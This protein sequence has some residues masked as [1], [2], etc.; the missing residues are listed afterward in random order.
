MTVGDIGGRTVEPMQD[1]C[2]VQL[3]QNKAY[4]YFKHATN[5]LPAG[6]EYGDAGS[7]AC[8]DPLYALPM[9]EVEYDSALKPGLELAKGY[10]KMVAMADVDLKD[11]HDY[12][13]I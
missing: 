4:P 12:E 6:N 13:E 2:Q 11:D 8:P 5:P 10:P 1:S 7:S 3:T 9:T